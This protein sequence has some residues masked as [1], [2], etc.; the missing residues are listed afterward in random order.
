MDVLGYVFWERQ[1]TLV[2]IF[3][4]WIA[5]LGI[6]A[7]NRQDN[8][9]MAVILSGITALNI[10]SVIYKLLQHGVV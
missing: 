1:M 7:M 4:V 9:P 5:V 10:C 2:M 6:W 3:N 8:L